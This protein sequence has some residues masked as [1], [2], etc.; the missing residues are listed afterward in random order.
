MNGGE[1]GWL[2][3]D[4]MHARMRAERTR[5]TEE[6]M[7]LSVGGAKGGQRRRRRRGRMWCVWGGWRS[8][9]R[10]VRMMR[11]RMETGMDG[12]ASLHT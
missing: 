9:W 5:S 8:E 4:G 7:V 10:G 2:G 3:V 6:F 12:V 1:W 11:T